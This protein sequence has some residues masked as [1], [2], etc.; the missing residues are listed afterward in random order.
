LFVSADWGKTALNVDAPTLAAIRLFEYTVNPVTVGPAY[1][2]FTVI[3]AVPCAFAD[4]I[5]G[6]P[7]VVNEDVADDVAFVPVDVNVNEYA[8]F[9]PTPENVK[10][11]AVDDARVSPVGVLID[12][13]VPVA[14]TI[15]LPD[16]CAKD[17]NA[18]TATGVTVI[19][20]GFVL[21]ADDPIA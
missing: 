10:E 17:E 8:V 15:R 20:L 16:A 7:I 14:A 5:T 1:V 3:V 19:E 2:Q 11:F 21:L 9:P 13:P 18:G 4:V 12:R 6:V